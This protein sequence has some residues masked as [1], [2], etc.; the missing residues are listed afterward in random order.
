[1]ATVIG[2]DL[3]YWNKKIEDLIAQQR[4]GW[5]PRYTF[6]TI[7]GAVNAYNGDRILA[8]VDH[9][10]DEDTLHWIRLLSS[11]YPIYTT[12]GRF[13]RIC[14]AGKIIKVEEFYG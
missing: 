7:T 6:N 4:D 1:M 2:L 14:K 5:P 8:A 10:S 11:W 12:D 9:E 13:I 3:G